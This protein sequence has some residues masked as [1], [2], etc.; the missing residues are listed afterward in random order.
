MI[1]E[2]LKD[3]KN[4]ALLR[5]SD[6]LVEIPALSSWPP[7]WVERA[8]LDLKYAGYIEREKRAVAKL[9]KMDAIKIAADIN[10][11]SITGLSVEARE[12]LKTVR[13]LTVGQAARIPGIRQGDIALLMIVARKPKH[14][15]N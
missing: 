6:V 5:A 9:S 11:D 2:L 10:Y 7:E 14:T 1:K 15:S 13:P 12:K 8:C 3:K 4:P